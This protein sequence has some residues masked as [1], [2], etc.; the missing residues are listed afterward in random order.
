MTLF[1]RRSARRAKVKKVS[2]NQV[3]ALKFNIFS[4]KFFIIFLRLPEMTGPS[5]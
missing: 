3:H 5:F 1:K 4:V 2:V